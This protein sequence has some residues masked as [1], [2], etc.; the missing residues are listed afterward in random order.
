MMKIA[1]ITATRILTAAA[2][3]KTDDLPTLGVEIASAF[4]I[5]G[6][7]IAITKVQTASTI[8]WADPKLERR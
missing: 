2:T 1:P 6:S 8:L 7:A 4:A 3:R 5:A